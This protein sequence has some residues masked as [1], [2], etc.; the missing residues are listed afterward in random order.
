MA[1]GVVQESSEVQGTGAVDRLPVRRLARGERGRIVEISGREALCRR[2][3]E[4]GIV[5]GAQVEVVQPGNPCVVRIGSTGGRWGLR[6]ADACRV[7]VE[8]LAKK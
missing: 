4:V 2:L 3:H 1:Q 5:V 6:S 8:R 7:I